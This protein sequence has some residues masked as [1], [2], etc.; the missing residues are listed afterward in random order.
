MK[1]I[2][3]LLAAFTFSA[4][5]ASAQTPAQTKIKHKVKTEHGA[6]AD[7]TPEQKA[8]RSAQKMAKSLGLSAEQTEKVRQLNLARFQE[9]QA[10]RAHQGTA[11]KTRASRQEMK[12][13]RE[14]YE[15]QLKQILS[16]DQFAK[17]AQLKAEKME[18]QKASRKAK[19]QK[20]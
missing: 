15:A 14:Q 10:K 13:G 4:G 7:K 6:K 17:Y 20:S 3:V 12:A 9:R 18:K 8:E 1:K 5:V 11:A 2:L 16:A 19:T